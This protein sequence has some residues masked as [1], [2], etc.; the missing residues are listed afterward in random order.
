MGRMLQ[1]VHLQRADRAADT[2]GA[3]GDTCHSG[4]T[5]ASAGTCHCRWGAVGAVGMG[6]L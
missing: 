4:V 3:S 2:G 6:L 1:A 5:V